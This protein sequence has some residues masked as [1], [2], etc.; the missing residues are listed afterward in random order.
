MSESEKAARLEAMIHAVRLANRGNPSARLVPSV[1]QDRLDVLAEELNTLLRRIT[2]QHL[3]A[4]QP[5]TTSELGERSTVDEETRM[6]R[7]AIDE[8]PDAIIWIDENG[9]LPYVNDATCRFLGYTREELSQMH[10]WDIDPDFP[11]DRLAEEWALYR[12]GEFG[13][14][15]LETRW[16]RK[17]GTVFPIEVSS[18]HMWFGDRELHVAF[19]RDITE[20]RK[21]LERLQSSRAHVQAVLS[22][23]SMILWAIDSEGVFTLQ[24][25]QGLTALGLE[26][27]ANLGM[28]IFDVYGYHSDVVRDVRSALAGTAATVI[29]DVGDM[30][31]ET[32]VKP[33]YGPS[34]ELLGVIGVSIDVT[35]RKR[36]EQERA[37]LQSQLLQAQK[38]ES[39][40]LLA[41]GVA[42]DFN[43]MLHVIMGFTDLLLHSLSDDSPLRSYAVEIDRAAQRA[44]EVTRQLLAFSRK[45]LI[46]PKPSDLNALVARLS[47]T[48]LRLIGEDIELHVDVEDNLW[49]VNVDPSQIDQ[50]VIN[51]AVNARDAM[52]K[53]GKLTVETANVKLDEPY[54]RQHVGARPG[55]HVL[56]A[57][58]D[59]GI[60]MDKDTLS[61]VFEPFFTTKERGK[62]TGLGL[63][64][65]YGI[66]KQND[67]FMSVYSEPGE[68]TTFK[69]Y[70]PRALEAGA[71]VVADDEQV[72]AGGSGTVLVVEDEASVRQLT[73]ALVESVGYTVVV[74]DGPAEAIAMCKREDLKVDVVLTDVVMPTMSGKELRDRLAELR[75]GI[76]VLF[77]SGYTANVIAHHG[78]LEKGVA[79]IAKPFSVRELARKLTEVLSTE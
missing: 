13:M 65:V 14:Q 34:G 37:R 15:H 49:I 61:R 60:G 72:S 43:N 63:A 77:T 3:G 53:G 8:A 30:T 20:R 38:L 5:D 45:Q 29:H 28:S 39:V 71:V 67:G 59:N 42:H 47:A 75:P 48:L 18:R 74:A 69:I 17:D 25:G 40:G 23:A 19:N 54:C 79:F 1:R 33:S 6:L 12:K 9:R 50:I 52:P 58:S 27:G 22:D 78:I 11:K 73:A 62:G 2:E 36:L 21:T 16:R 7:F 41:G 24:E 10:L 64:T 76:K 51:L 32:R 57:V 44:Q 26:P 4:K 46:S 56:L 66:V 31:F 70:L 68:G 55:D 35:E